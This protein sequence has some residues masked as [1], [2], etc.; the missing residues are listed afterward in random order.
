V[1]KKSD[2]DHLS[3]Q[4]RNPVSRTTVLSNRGGADI[5]EDR[6]EVDRNS[7]FR[8]LKKIFI[9]EY[10]LLSQFRFSALP[11]SDTSDCS[12]PTLVPNN[13]PLLYNKIK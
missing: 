3:D 9:S 5:N 4:S 6:T 12:D 7:D 1:T 8:F 2:I 10:R 11:I 13:L